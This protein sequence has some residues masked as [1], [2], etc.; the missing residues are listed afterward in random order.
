MK[1]P[2]RV[3]TLYNREV[4]FHSHPA[5]RQDEWVIHMFGGMTG[6]SFV[7]I[8]AFDGIFHSNTMALQHA[9]DWSGSL[10]E[11]NTENF[12]SAKKY[13]GK[14]GNQ[15]IQACI[16]ANAGQG[17]F[18][19]DGPFS[20]LSLYIPKECKRR[21]IGNASTS[22]QKVITLADL[23]EQI[24]A[25]RVVHYLSLGIEG[26]E[27]NTLY[28]YFSNVPP[29]QQ[30]IFQTITFTSHYPAERI[31]ALERVMWEFG[32]DLEEV[33]GFCYCWSH[34]SLTE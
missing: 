24:K 26:A 2:T 25:P 11:A 5:Y 22:Q 17:R 19:N 31:A 30:R 21:L 27:I 9:F 16:G 18:F 15:V 4:E 10:V 1:Q 23:L 32:Y 20:G 14:I 6:G 33:R 8:G 34:K 29:E 28:S 3:N 12:M 7:E 13:R